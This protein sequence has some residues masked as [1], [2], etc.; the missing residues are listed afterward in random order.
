MPLTAALVRRRARKRPDP[1]PPGKGQRAFQR[2]LAALLLLCGAG[3]ARA[4]SE[5]KLLVFAKW[6]GIQEAPTRTGAATGATVTAPMTTTTPIAY[7]QLR[8]VPSQV[9]SGTPMTLATE[10]PMSTCP[11]ARPRSAGPARCA[12]TSAA[13]PKKA[14]C[15][16][17]ATKRAAI[18]VP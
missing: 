11:T 13:T 12:A 7:R 14:P 9:T 2:L 1:P 15:G 16:R 17:P 6:F 18:S 8:A 10:R 4:D 3:A 5:Y